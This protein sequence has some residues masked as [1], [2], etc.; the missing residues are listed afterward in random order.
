MKDE[1]LLN[2]WIITDLDFSLN[3]NHHV[4]GFGETNKTSN[5]SNK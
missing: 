3:G 2:P 4:V 5:S 1:E